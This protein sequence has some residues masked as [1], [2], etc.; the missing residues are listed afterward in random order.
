M[1]VTLA[2]S[3]LLGAQ[4]AG[5][6]SQKD[7]DDAVKRGVEYLKTAPSTAGHLQGHNCD[8]LILLTLIHAG[9]S[10]KH[11]V[12]QKLLNSVLS[13]P[14]EKTYKVALQAMLLEDLDPGYYQPRIAQC[15]QFL[16]DNQATNGQ[17]SY[18]QPTNAVV[19]M[20]GL[21]DKPIESGK[22]DKPAGVI[23][24]GAERAKSR[25][26]RTIAVTQTKT[27]GEQ[28]DNSNT[29]YAALGLRACFDAKIKIP[30]N[31]VH[32]ARKWW[33]EAQYEPEDGV[34]ANA[35]ASGGGAR[36]AGW[37]YTSAARDGD[38]KPTHAMT[39]GAVGATVIYEHMMGKDWKKDKVTN[40]GLQWV[41][42]HF[43][44]NTNYYYMYALERAGILYGVESIGNHNW[45]FEGARLL[46]QNQNADG[47]W[48]KRE[49]KDENTWDTCFAILFLKKATKAIATEAGGRRKP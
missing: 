5:A 14:L 11:P 28:G 2:F 39:A 13:A 45:Y 4:A 47:S 35:E 43:A 49:N 19:T 9:M 10:D 41:A 7:I 34:A 12:F 23:Q 26:S 44:V 30:D 15:A 20:P 21:G 18:G 37:S 31:V 42:K 40:N 24:F 36:P 22:K 1:S 38:R 25:P 17:W 6:P 32:L 33:V 29:Q 27:T 3:L 46:L 48:G 8:E 16:I